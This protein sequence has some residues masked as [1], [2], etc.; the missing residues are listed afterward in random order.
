MSVI[1][2][3]FTTDN[4]LIK[5]P[6]WAR[7]YRPHRSSPDKSWERR[8]SQTL[9]ESQPGTTTAN[10]NPASQSQTSHHK[11]YRRFNLRCVCTSSRLQ[12]TNLMV[13]LI[14]CS[15]ST[16]APCRRNENDRDLLHRHRL[17]NVVSIRRRKRFSTQDCNYQGRK[18]TSW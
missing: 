3:V 8:N 5:L 7:R 10:T 15:L 2:H 4:L 12:T 1:S 17:W 6:M 11:T 13:H 9:H 14:P 18:R 16:P